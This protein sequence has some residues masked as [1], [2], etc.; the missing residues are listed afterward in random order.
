MKRIGFVVFF[1]LRNTGLLIPLLVAAFV[2]RGDG[3]GRLV[4]GRLARFYVP[5]ALC[6]VVP[7]LFQLSPWIWDN[8]KFMVWWHVAS[9]VL[10]A[11]LLARL[12]RM[13][14][15]PRVAA[16]MKFDERTPRSW[17]FGLGKS[18]GSR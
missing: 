16:G 7:N 5:F 18:T 9:A 1:W 13:G 15:W 11:L 8:I 14:P 10:V 4:P 12:W 2:W 3:G 6:F 17:G